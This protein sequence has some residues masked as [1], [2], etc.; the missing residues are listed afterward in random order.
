MDQS[1]ERGDAGATQEQDVG[2]RSYLTTQKGDR[3][4]IRWIYKVKHN[5]DGS[6]N[7]YKARLVAKGYAQTHGVDYEETFAPMGKDDDG[8]D[9]DCASRGER[10]A[11]P[12][13]GCKECLSSR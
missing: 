13:N 4:S 10:V 6:I 2:S 1:H 3:M 7:R 9:R 12:P 5:V 8:T 11:P